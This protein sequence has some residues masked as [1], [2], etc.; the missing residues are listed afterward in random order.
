MTATMPQYDEAR[1]YANKVRSAAA[2]FRREVSALGGKEGRALLAAYLEKNNPPEEI[3]R[4]PVERFV[5]SIH[6][7]GNFEAERLYRTAGLNRRTARGSGRK[8]GALQVRDLTERERLSLAA[9]LRPVEDLV[10]S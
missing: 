1:E 2:R 3:D 9:A 8:N 10:D 7:I 6:R 5:R 4:M